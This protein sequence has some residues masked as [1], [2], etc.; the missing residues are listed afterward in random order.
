MT[1]ILEIDFL[2][3]LAN[4]G[5]VLLKHILFSFYAIGLNDGGGLL[6][7]CLFVC[8]LAA[9]TFAIPWNLQ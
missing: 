4:A 7:S 9:V 8:L 1:Y 2:G 3:F 6:F 5:T